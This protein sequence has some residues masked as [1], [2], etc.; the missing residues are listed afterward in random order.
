M[1]AQ[2]RRAL[3]AGVEIGEGVREEGRDGLFGRGADEGAGDVVAPELVAEGGYGGGGGGV[4][5]AGDFEVEGAEGEVGG[6]GTGGNEG[7]EGVRWGVVFSGG[8]GM[9]VG[10]FRLGLGCGTGLLEEAGTI[11]SGGLYFCS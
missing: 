6:L 7:E 2:P 4:G 10:F 1:F 3:R 9:L 8:R 5:D 11:L